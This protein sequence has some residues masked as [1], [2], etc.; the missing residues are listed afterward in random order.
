MAVKVS[1]TSEKLA[2]LGA[3]VVDAAAVCG[4]RW[5][6][7]EQVSEVTLTRADG[8]QVHSHVCHR[9]GVRVHI[10][11]NEAWARWRQG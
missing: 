4:L 5:P 2:K 7:A 9:D 3:G 1:C 8:P 6:R 11:A 10:H